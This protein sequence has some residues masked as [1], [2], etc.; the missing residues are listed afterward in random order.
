MSR[1]DDALYVERDGRISVFMSKVEVGQ[2]LKTA[3]AQLAAEELDIDFSRVL[4]VRADTALSADA[5]Y[6]A[7]SNSIQ[8][9]GEWVRRA[10]ASA[11]HVMLQ[12][13]ADAWGVDATSLWVEDGLIKER[14][15]V[16][17]ITYGQLMGGRTFDCDIIDDISLKDP[18]RYTTVGRSVRGNDLVAKV[19]GGGSF[20]QDLVLP[21][22]LH[23]RV[24][25]PPGPRDMLIDLDRDAAAHITGVL[26][27][28]RDGHFVGVV[29]EREEQAVD[30]ANALRAAARW[31]R[32][33]PLPS[34]DAIYDQLQ[35]GEGRS[36][37]IVDGAPVD[38][39]VPE[40]KVPADAKQTLRALYKRPFQLHASLGPSAAL[41]RWNQGQLHVWSHTQGVFPLRGALAQALG[42]DVEAVRVQ[43]VEG[44]GCYG[45]NG[46]DD[47]ALDAALLARAVPG[48]PVR[49]QWMR[50]DE[51]AWEACGSAM[52]LQ[53]QAS[54][55]ASGHV[56]DWNH[57]VWSFTHSGRPRASEGVSNLL[58]AWHLETPL[59]APQARPGGGSHGGIHRNA[60]PLYAFP[61]RRVVKHFVRDQPL[62][63]SALRGLG[64]YGNVFAIESFM[65]ELALAAECDPLD[66]RLR[67]LED[68]RARAVLCAAA[69]RA[70]WMSGV[71]RGA[72]G[73]GRGMGIGF[74]QY[75]NEKCYAAVVAQVCVENDQIHLERLV[76]AADAG[77]IVNPEGMANQLEGGVMQAASWTLYEQVRYGANGIESRDWDTYPILRFDRAPEIEAVLLDQPALPS[78][79]CGEATQGPTPAA[80]ANAVFVA[81]GARLREIPFTPERVRAALAH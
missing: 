57:D 78:K 18:C 42:V 79:G 39:D 77:Q 33:A 46:A 7:G 9:V 32:S 81:C 37:R 48:R 35:T 63:V 13:A 29:A 41:A 14:T 3:I 70:G 31:E 24:V 56:V 49:V 51:H 22:M 15:G 73:A 11:R 54:L 8:T 6:T 26:A 27:V 72:S 66:F 65:D 43:H 52:L 1:I 30:A 4:I 69:D 75:K 21:E 45:H 5:S 38:G 19:T 74:A 16:R 59:P 17:Q 80:I 2:G 60:D 20:I 62:R 10:A 68:E 36:L 61:H 40:V 25:R 55:D 64:A 44:S 67:H 12:R 71:K 23:G 76:V 34:S 58:A 50:E 47:V 28:V 53:L